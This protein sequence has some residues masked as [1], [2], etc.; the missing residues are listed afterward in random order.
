[1]TALHFQ[2]PGRVDLPIEVHDTDLRLVGRVLSSD[3]LTVD[4]GTYFVEARLPDGSV[5]QRTVEV[6]GEG[7]NEVNLSEPR[8][9]RFA[10]RALTREPRELGEFRGKDALYTYSASPGLDEERPLAWV[11]TFR[12]ETL[13]GWQPVERE[14]I[15]SWSGRWRPTFQHE[16]DAIALERPD[17]TM[18]IVPTPGQLN[19]LLRFEVVVDRRREVP[20]LRARVENE[21]AHALLGFLNLDLM[22]DAEVLTHSHALQGERLLRDK[23]ADPVAAAAGALALLRMNALDRLHD[24]THNLVR[25]FP[26]LPDGA[27]VRAEHLARLGHHREAAELLRTIPHRGLPV[28]SLGFGFAVDRLRTYVAAWPEDSELRRTLFL[29]A[30]YATATDFSQPVTTFSGRGPD[31]P[32]PAPRSGESDAGSGSEGAVDQ[33]RPVH[34]EL[35]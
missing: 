16:G 17:G 18:T 19:E 3:S 32:E 8:E 20:E 6:T 10:M 24:W 26:W 35:A 27:V 15:F 34:E 9:E 28:L 31:S 30:G 22:E 33:P 11:T 21:A 7:D 2:L 29:L 4:P 5:R 13:G 25:W 1:M 23:V 14:V 12:L